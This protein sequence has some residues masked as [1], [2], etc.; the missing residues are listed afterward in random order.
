MPLTPVLQVQLALVI[1][2][3]W[4]YNARLSFSQLTSLG[5]LDEVMLSLFDVMQTFVTRLQHKVAALA[6]CAV[7][8]IPAAELPETVSVSPSPRLFVWLFGCLFVC[9]CN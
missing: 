5:K 1:L 9:T 4:I 8:L 7:L 2:S 3:S 6:L